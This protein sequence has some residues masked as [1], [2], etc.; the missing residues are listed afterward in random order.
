VLWSCTSPATPPGGVALHLPARGVLLTG[1]LVAESN[2]KVIVGVFN[3]D[4]EQVHRSIARLARTGAHTAGF[5]HGETVLADAAD[6]LATC[7]DPFG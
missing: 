7:T 6:R 5:G 1:D 3:T 4:R 2:G